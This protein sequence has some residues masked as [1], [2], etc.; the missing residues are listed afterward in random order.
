MPLRGLFITGTDTGVGKTCVA[1]AVIRHLRDGGIRVGAYK[2]V[3]SGSEP[4]PFGPRWDDVVRLA[5]AVSGDIPPDRICPQRFHAPLA[6]PV[7]ARREDK[8]VDRVLCSDGIDWWTDHA[9]VLIVE[10]VGGLL[11]PLTDEETV[12]DFAVEVGFPLVI[13]SRTG[14]GT[15]NHTLLTVEAAERRGLEVAGI[16]LNQS[17]P[18]R[19]ADAAVE[20]NAAE[21]SRRLRVPILG[22]FAHDAGGDLIQQESFRRIDWLALTGTRRD[23]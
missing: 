21:L 8:R 17:T 16:V 13:V 19:G 12:A 3:A 22:V 20:T 14:L 1:A 7:A 23:L 10:G 4:G 11:C 6:P 9:D 5:A 2:P 15:I 18:Q